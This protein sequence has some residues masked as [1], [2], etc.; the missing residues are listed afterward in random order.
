VVELDGELHNDPHSLHR[1]AV[2]SD[3]LA[4]L[5]H[6][7][8]RFWNNS[9]LRDTPAMLAV[10]ARRVAALSQTLAPTVSR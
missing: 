6:E 9:V 5:G 1:V 3:A 7:V 10:V 8:L 2:R 4:R